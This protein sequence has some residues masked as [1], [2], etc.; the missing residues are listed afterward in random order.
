MAI[1][2]GGRA[3]A[4][5]REN[6]LKKKVVTLKSKGVTPHLVSILIG[7]D[8]ASVL[9]VGLKKKAA[10]RIGA[11]VTIVNLDPSFGINGAVT[12]IKRFN[13]DENVNGIMVQLPL[14]SDI[15]AGKDEILDSISPKKD[16]DGLRAKSKFLH[17][18]SKAVVEILEEA[19]RK[20]KSKPKT[21]CVVGKKGMV[22]APLVRALKKLGYKLID[23]KKEA[24]VLISATG[25][26]RLIRGSMVKDG[27]IVIDV[28]SPKGDIDFKS[29]FKK[30]G[31]ITPVPGG[32][33]P[34]TITCLLENLLLAC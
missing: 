10:E 11:M 30:A 27:A 34:V 31:F 15:S 16:V 26:P 18:T 5:N 28:G 22:G 17:P 2:F 33:G 12:M 1:I 25:T 6:T 23:N 13:K 8:P 4:K 3:F 32:V 29:A 21:V 24:D 19:L 7:S 14:P 20:T 9:Y